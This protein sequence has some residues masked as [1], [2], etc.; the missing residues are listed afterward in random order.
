[1]IPK[2][3][4]SPSLHPGL[5]ILVILGIFLTF[6]W[7]TAYAQKSP[8]PALAVNKDTVA[9]TA[10]ATM[11][12]PVPTAYPPPAVTATSPLAS[13]P[14]ANTA[15]APTNT[16]PAPSSFERP[17]VVIGSYSASLDTISPGDQFDLSV[18]LVNKGQGIANNVVAFFTPA[19]LIPLGT[20]GVIAVGEIAPGNHGHLTQTLSVSYD[21]YG[22]AYASIDMNVSYSGDDG[23]TYTDKF[24]INLPVYTS[25][26][27]AAT[28]TPTATTTAAP[29][30]RPQ[31]VIGSYSADV[32]KLQPG[33]LFNL[34]INLDN[35]G[36]ADARR[37]TMIIG[38]GSNASGDIGGTPGA[39]GTSG[40]SAEL[41]NFA[42]IGSSNIQSLGDLPAGS[43]LTIKQN[44]IVN[45]S[46]NPGAYSMKISFAYLD[47]RGH[48]FT[49][50]Q[51][52]TLLV[53]SLPQVEI[54]F[55]RETGPL[56]AG[57][58]AVLPIHV[59]NMGHKSTILGNMQVTAENLQ[60]ANNNLAVGPLD[61]GLDFVMDA[62]MTPNQ[63]GPLDLTVTIDYIDDFNQPQKISKTLRVDVL[64]A[65][66]VEPG[67]NNSGK[68][69]APVE[70]GPSANETF[71][72]KV[73]RL[74]RGLIG[75]DSGVAAPS[76]QISPA[77]NPQS[78]NGAS[79]P[80][81]QPARPLKGP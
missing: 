67:I 46:T 25:S 65:P 14:P 66:S 21:A 75:L 26:S 59:I 19:D 7:N 13:Q 38:G 48:N 47:E 63:A 11:P 22:K 34:Q 71:L 51:V 17:L 33:I 74:V 57:Q 61:P 37:V 15:Q 6:G 70:P 79:S 68:D 56:Y 41:T 2:F 64:E 72:Q 73:W 5:T 81:I 60:F 40:G 3:T 23:A 20:G 24:T 54:G 36:N 55:Y 32:P 12:V 52:I 39:G 16:P 44:L 31:L 58:P 50:D 76:I 9:A 28:A 30:L 49:D 4:R 62:S 45:V 78:G 29:I 77:V 18:K 35:M 69:G 43:K 27:S 1:M 42:P 8:G 10:T 80:V 53:Y